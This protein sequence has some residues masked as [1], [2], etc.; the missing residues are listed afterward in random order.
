MRFFESKYNSYLSLILRIY[1]GAV[2]IYASIHKIANPESFAI[3]IATYDILPLY[4]VNLMAI[5]L[6]YIEII[7]GILIIIGPFQKEGA[8]LISAMMT[9]FLIALIIAIQKGINASCGCFASQSIEEDS[10]SYKTVI[11]DLIWLLIAL[12]VLLFDKRPLLTFKKERISL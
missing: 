11:R 7:S 2:F 3:D 9:I 1:I 4:L 6:P 8:L 10:I 5:V 12:Y